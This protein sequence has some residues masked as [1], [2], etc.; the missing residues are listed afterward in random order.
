MGYFSATIGY[1]SATIGYFSGRHP[2][3]PLGGLVA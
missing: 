1:F 2:V 3:F